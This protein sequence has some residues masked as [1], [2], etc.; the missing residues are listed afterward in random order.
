MKFLQEAFRNLHPFLQ[1]IFIFCVAIVG[2]FISLFASYFINALIC[3]TPTNLLEYQKLLSTVS[4]DA[5]VCG[6]LVMNSVN[7]VLAFLCAGFFYSFLMG[8]G[9]G[10]GLNSRGGSK[11]M[12]MLIICA[13]IMVLAFTPFIDLTSR[14]NEWLLQKTIFYESALALENQS[15][16]IIKA[17]LDIDTFGQFSASLVAIAIIPAIAEE[18]FF[19][20]ALQPLF[21]KWSGSIHIGIWVSAFIFSAIHMQF[22]GF[23][24]RLLLGAGFGYLVV[25]SGSL[26]IAIMCHFINNAS[27]VIAAYLFG[28]EWIQTGLDASS[29]PLGLTEILMTLICGA[30]I[31]GLALLMRKQSV[32]KQNEVEYL[33]R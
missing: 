13:S 27:A 17:M 16:E 15:K 5:G 7:Q 20:G 21:A 4:S 28:D 32:W 24:P 22:L 19:R 1:F 23:I 10:I 3:D 30:L 29:K 14:L 31:I 12:W 2:M 18:Y 11:V 9:I 26:W 8:G 6:N 33:A 25:L